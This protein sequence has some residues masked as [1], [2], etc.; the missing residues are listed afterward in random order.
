MGTLGKKSATSSFVLA[1]IS[2]MSLTATGCAQFNFGGLFSKQ[3][4]PGAVVFGILSQQQAGAKVLAKGKD[5]ATG[6][7][8]PSGT[9]VPITQVSQAD[10]GTAIA[11]GASAPPFVVTLRNP[12]QIPATD[13]KF[14]I[15]PPEMAQHFDIS[16]DC[17]VLDIENRGSCSAT[18]LASCW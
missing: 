3:A 4:T 8:S 15:T 14:T 11:L 12:G 6:T 5:V 7:T 16:N 2:V 18:T 10:L 17:K 1:L 9:W 13:F